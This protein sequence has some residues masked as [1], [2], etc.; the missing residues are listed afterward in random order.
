MS[1]VV[2]RKSIAASQR[3]RADEL[4]GLLRICGSAMVFNRVDSL[5]GPERRAPKPAQ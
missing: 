3:D 4:D 2:R 1:R 5:A